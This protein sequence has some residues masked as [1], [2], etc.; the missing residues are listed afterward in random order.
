MADA[1]DWPSDAPVAMPSLI[2]QTVA[3]VVKAD[4]LPESLGDFC[5]IFC[6]CT[7]TKKKNG[8]PKF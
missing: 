5:Q 2:G 6:L 7:E 4:N 3:G 8:D 1:C